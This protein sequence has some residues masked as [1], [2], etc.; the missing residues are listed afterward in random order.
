MKRTLGL[1]DAGAEEVVDS[2]L[3]TELWCYI[4]NDEQEQVSALGLLPVAVVTPMR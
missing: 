2:T 4:D 1:R 3:L